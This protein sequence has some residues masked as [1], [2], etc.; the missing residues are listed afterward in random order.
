MSGAYHVRR[1]EDWGRLQPEQHLARCMAKGQALGEN[2]PLLTQNLRLWNEGFRISYPRYRHELARIAAK[3][4]HETGLGCCR[5]IESESATY[6]CPT[7]DD[8][9]FRADIAIHLDRA[10]SDPEVQLVYWNCHAY[11]PTAASVYKKPGTV[12]PFGP[13]AGDLYLA[14]NGYAVRPSAPIETLRNHL[15]ASDFRQQVKSVYVPEVLSLWVRHPASL[16]Y[17]QN[18]ELDENLVRMLSPAPELP[19]LS[20]FRESLCQIYDL[21]S[22]LGVS[23]ESTG[24]RSE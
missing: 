18:R 7:D 16:H 2:I 23:H 24:G 21:T 1:T 14:S 12:H 5:A 8:D 17:L 4:W 9:L 15:C 20:G 3:S 19:E 11:Y 6:I 22:A 10:F 13:A